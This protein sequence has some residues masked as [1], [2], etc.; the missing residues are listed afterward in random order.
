VCLNL[1]ECFVFVGWL[2]LIFVL[3]HRENIVG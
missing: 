2:V 1:T 3:R